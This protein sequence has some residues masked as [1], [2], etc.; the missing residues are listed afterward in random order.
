M[1]NAFID[2][3]LNFLSLIFQKFYRLSK[4][5]QKNKWKDYDPFNLWY[6]EVKSQIRRIL[7]SGNIDLI[8]SSSSPFE[9]HIIASKVS[10][11][12]N[13]PWIADYRDPWT[14]NHTSDF[15]D[16][17]KKIFETSII[18]KASALLVA[19][20]YFKSIYEN[21]S[22]AP[23]FVLYNGFKKRNIQKT[24]QNIHQKTRI[25]YTGSIYPSFQN[26]KMILNIISMNQIAKDYEIVFLGDSSKLVSKYL[27]KKRIDNSVILFNRVSR[28][29]S[30]KW[31]LNADILLVFDW[32][33]LEHPGILPTKFFEYMCFDSLILVTGKNPSSELASI[34]KQTNS[35][36]YKS[37]EAEL[38]DFL[39]EKNLKFSKNSG[40][41]AYSYES[42]AGLL[43]K[44]IEKII[45]DMDRAKK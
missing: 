28:D 3:L 25:V 17:N 36:V 7:A 29:E 4:L 11:L 22:S 40:V 35:G 21:F 2:Y 12:F 19:S 18:S 27:V 13:I 1:D 44:F 26:Y 34:L 43:L 41:E 15:T 30:Y 45:K 5:W 20:N 32:D 24:R 8:L 31:Q 6:L 14:L 23:I 33:N 37:S 38:Y 16:S 39:L 10:E 9:C 42:Q